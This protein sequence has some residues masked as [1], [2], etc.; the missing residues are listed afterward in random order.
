MA[1][2]GI[3]ELER[4]VMEFMWFYGQGTCTGVGQVKKASVAYVC[5]WGGDFMVDYVPPGPPLINLFD[6]HMS[7]GPANKS[8]E[9]NPG[10]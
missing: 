10:E 3:R 1:A 8:G 9:S 2:C 4:Y 6:D 5:V 7:S